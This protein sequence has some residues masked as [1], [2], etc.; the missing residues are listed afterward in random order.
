MAYGYI[1]PGGMCFPN[2]HKGAVKAGRPCQQ[3][4]DTR[5][6]GRLTT[7]EQNIS[8]GWELWTVKSLM[9]FIHSFI[10]LFIN[11]PN[12]DYSQYHSGP[13]AMLRARDKVNRAQFLLSRIEVSQVM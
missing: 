2:L 5:D 10:H 12:N 4:L 3:T 6:V 13:G 8:F 9:P 7:L 1:W 11:S